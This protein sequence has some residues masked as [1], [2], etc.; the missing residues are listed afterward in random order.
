MVRDSGVRESRKI[1]DF[2]KTGP[3]RLRIFYA[4]RDG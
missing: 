3:P 2:R 4:E 1:A